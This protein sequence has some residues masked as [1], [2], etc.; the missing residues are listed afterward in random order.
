[1]KKVI[2]SI[3]ISAVSFTIHAQESRKA[4]L[5]NVQLNEQ[6]PNGRACMAD[7]INTFSRIQE[8]DIFKVPGNRQ[9]IICLPEAQNYDGDGHPFI[10]NKRWQQV[11]C[12]A[13][14]ELLENTS[15]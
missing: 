6:T 15:C 14:A 4:A 8:K 10:D 12:L 11:E 13:S 5:V 3:L 2:Y 7:I 1:M 9:F